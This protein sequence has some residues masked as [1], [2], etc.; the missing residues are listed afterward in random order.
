MSP[1]R[2]SLLFTNP[3]V[4]GLHVTEGTEDDIIYAVEDDDGHH[5]IERLVRRAWPF[6]RTR[7]V[8]EIDLRLTRNLSDERRNELL[9]ALLWLLRGVLGVPQRDRMK[10]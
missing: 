1:C 6:I 4:H 5:D 3:E 9:H 10:R 7:P 2:V 8:F